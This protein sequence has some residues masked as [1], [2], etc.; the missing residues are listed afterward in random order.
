VEEVCKAHLDDDF[1]DSD[2]NAVTIYRSTLQRGGAVYTALWTIPLGG[3]K[4]A[5]S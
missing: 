4:G 2:I 5:S 1:G 3:H